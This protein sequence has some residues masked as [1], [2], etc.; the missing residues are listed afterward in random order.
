M[1]WVIRLNRMRPPTPKKKDFTVLS[2]SIPFLASPLHS[3]PNNPFE[4]FAQ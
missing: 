4:R 3:F 2:Q 1:I